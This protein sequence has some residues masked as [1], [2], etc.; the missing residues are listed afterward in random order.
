MAFNALSWL[1]G[2][3]LAILLSVDGY[4][5]TTA[6]CIKHAFTS[7]RSDSSDPTLINPSNWNECHVF[8]N[9][10]YDVGNV[11]GTKALDWNNGI[12]QT[13]TL[14]GSTTFT[15]ANPVVGMRY[16]LIFTQSGSGKATVTLP[17]EVKFMAGGSNQVDLAANAISVA[18]LDYNGTTYNG[19]IPSGGSSG[20]PGIP[21]GSTTQCQYNN[22]GVFAGITGCTT[23]GTKT[24]FSSGNFQATDAIFEG[25]NVFGASATSPTNQVF[26][27]MA[28]IGSS[29]FR[30][31]H[32]VLWEGKANNGTERT[33]WWRQF[34]DVTSN[35]GASQFLLQQNLAGAGWVNKLSVSDDGT[36]CYGDCSTDYLEHNT[37]SV[38]GVKMI[39]WQ[40]ASGVPVLR[41]T[42]DTLSNKTI[43]TPAFTG[44]LTVPTSKTTM[45]SNATLTTSSNSYQFFDPNGSDRDVTLP[46]GVL[47]QAFLIK[48]IGG[49][50][51]ITIK[52]SGGSTVTTATTGVIKTLVYDGSAWQIL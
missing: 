47:G 4:G 28:N 29:G 41:D 6:P 45:S 16:H 24:T 33:V 23:N 40:N 39:T 1:V 10:T 26:L 42:S 38:T 2:G 32:A 48:H 46:S 37:S 35:A 22:A 20:A 18:Y 3:V 52:A 43:A 36:F 50:N 13:M 44:L 30:D 31:S 8:S 11:N 12:T 17:S 15:F 5:A 27:G 34:V 21:G 19:F 51:T 25:V 14:T 9:L 7:S 49:A